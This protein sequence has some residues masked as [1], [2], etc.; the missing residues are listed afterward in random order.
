MKGLSQSIFSSVFPA[1]KKFLASPSKNFISNS[2]FSYRSV[3]LLPSRQDFEYYVYT[4]PSSIV[5]KKL[6]SQSPLHTVSGIRTPKLEKL[7]VDLVAD[8]DFY[9]SYQGNER[10][11]LFRNA[12]S[13]Y[14]LS[15]KTLYRYA[16]RRKCRQELEAYLHQN[17]ILPASAGERGLL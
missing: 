7:L 15:L 16:Q 4:T 3:F 2:I 12:F 6:V 14:Q 5:I 9:Y 11:T 10:T 1:Q 8:S 13:Q 17:Q